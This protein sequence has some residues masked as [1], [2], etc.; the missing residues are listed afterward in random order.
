[1][2]WR[3]VYTAQAKKDA[4]KAKGSGLAPA[5]SRL[6]AV[7]ETDPHQA[8]PPYEQLSGDLRGAISRRINRQ[9]RLVYQVFPEERVVKVIRMWTHY[10]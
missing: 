6:L 10:E 5:I 3:L 7:L 9:H 1:V 8:P 4:K 2:K